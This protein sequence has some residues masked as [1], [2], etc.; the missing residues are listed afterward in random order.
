MTLVVLSVLHPVV[1]HGTVMSRYGV[2]CAEGTR[3]PFDVATVRSCID[4]V[5]PSALKELAVRSMSPPY[6]PA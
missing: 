3:S 2:L 5:A 4:R 1:V 6:S